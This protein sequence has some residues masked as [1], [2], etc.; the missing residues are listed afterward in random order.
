[1]AWQAI[2]G[3]ALAIIGLMMAQEVH[4]KPLSV[5]AKWIGWVISVSFIVGGLYVMLRVGSM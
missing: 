5:A 1:M 2:C 3:I 4:D